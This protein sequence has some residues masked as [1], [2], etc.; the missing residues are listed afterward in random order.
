MIHRAG[1][2]LTY[3]QFN[4]IKKSKFICKHYGFKKKITSIN[5]YTVDRKNKRVFV[6][7]IE[8]VKYISN[9]ENIKT[10]IPDGKTIQIPLPHNLKLRNHQATIINYLLN[11]PFTDDKVDRGLGSFTMQLK[12][13]LGKTYIGMGLFH[14]F[15]VKTMIIVKKTLISQWKKELLKMFPNLV[16]GE[17]H[18][19][20]KVD[21]PIVLASPDSLLDKKITIKRQGE[22]KKIELNPLQWFGEFGLT[23]I[24]EIQD[25]CTSRKVKI[26]RR[27]RGLRSL[28]MSATCN[29]RLDNMDRISH[30]YFGYPV[31]MIDVFPQFKPMVSLDGIVVHAHKINYMG[32]DRYTIPQMSATGLSYPK[33]ISQLSEDPYRSKLIVTETL[34][35]VRQGHSTFVFLD[36]IELIDSLIPY[37]RDI[38]GKADGILAPESKVYSVQG[39]STQ[40]EKDN[41][42]KQGLI[43]LVT[44]GCGSKGLSFDNYTAMVIG[45]PRRNGFLQINNRIFRLDG[46][47]DRPRILKYIVDKRTGLKTQYNGFRQAL[48]KE[49]PQTTY[50]EKIINYTDIR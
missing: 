14:H 11:N 17:Y 26:F 5:G 21:G 45:H 50:H 47:R 46:P 40:E 31:D 36:R 32:P 8:A 3:E 28:C 23:V 39:K 48:K 16:I 44:Y 19:S 42:K 30:M 18:G 20:K 41:A 43:C 25:L 9:P 27:C 12:A 13:G 33:M 1:L 15:H 35:L 37:F 7:P 38:L 4:K 6:A 24:D 29:H 22:K 10:N 34:D 49:Y 2:E